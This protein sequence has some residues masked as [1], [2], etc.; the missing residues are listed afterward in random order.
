MN[1]DTPLLREFVTDGSDAAFAELVRRHIN[2][3]YGVTLRRLNGD[4]AQAADVTQQ[5]FIDL[6]RKAAALPPDVILGGWLHRHASFTASKSVRSEVRRKQREQESVAMHE[7]T[8]ENLLHQLGPELDEALDELA[9]DER[10]VLVLRFFERRNLRSVGEALG[11]SDDAAQKRVARALERLR[12]VFARRGHAVPALA[13]ATVLTQAGAIAAPAALASAAINAA[14]LTTGTGAATAAA[15]AAITGKTLLPL[16]IMNKT[17]IAIATIM[18]A[19]FITATLYQ[20]HQIKQ[21][22]A[23]NQRLADEMTSMREE[24]D[25]LSAANQEFQA[26]AARAQADR[27]ELLRLRGIIASAA[28]PAGKNPTARP[29]ATAASDHN[30]STNTTYTGSVRASVP[31]GHTLVMGGWPTTPGKRTLAL[32]TSTPSPVTGGG[33]ETVTLESTYIE[34]P[35]SIVAE[36]GWE[37]FQAMSKDASG[38]YGPEQVAA[39]LAALEKVDGAEITS[40]PRVITGSGSPA[41]IQIGGQD[42]PRTT[43]EFLPITSADGQSVDLSVSNSVGTASSPNQQP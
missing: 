19:C 38:L 2:L 22:T 13:L 3:V 9:A 31:A 10:D 21:L 37:Q 29:P 26:S 28:K 4:T 6:A 12:I 8:G 35:E 30:S 42:G 17:K 32:I 27:K 34:V 1:D 36:P 14:L 23:A 7:N 39:F 5:V 16:F 20:Q 15:H 33:K 40:N 43:A 41:S 25:A 24:Q 11:L 18:G